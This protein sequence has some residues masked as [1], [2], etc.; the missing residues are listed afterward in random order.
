MKKYANAVNVLPKELV[1][2]LKK[3]YTG[4]LYVPKGNH[5]RERRKLVIMLHDQKMDAKEIASIVGL[6]IR[7]VHQ[8]IAHECGKV[9]HCKGL[10]KKMY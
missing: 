8:I 7:R 1:A 3:H 10:D 6:G 4:M 2:E 5:Y 9:H